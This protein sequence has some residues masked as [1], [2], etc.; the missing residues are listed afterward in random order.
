MAALIGAGCVWY[1]P[2]AVATICLAIA[3]PDLRAG[4][5]LAR[6]IPA[7]AGG[8]I[9]ARFRYAWGALKVGATA[10]LL[11]FVSIRLFAGD[12]DVPSAF[13]AS[14]LLALGGFSL[15]AALTA[16]GLLATYRAGMRIW[17]GKSVN[18]ARALVAGLLVVG[19]AYAVLGPMC[20]WLARRSPRASDSH[21]DPAGMTVTLGCMFA[22]PVI[23]LLILD[24]VGKHVIADR[25]GKFGA[26]VPTVGKWNS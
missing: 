24:W 19:F 20:I 25:P 21:S 7:K 14:A 11:M 1:P 10:L 18:R 26:K 16:S 15:S 5:Q 9:C 2:L 6:T 8:T 3:A 22:G 17:I 13:K 12:R 23:I 4:R